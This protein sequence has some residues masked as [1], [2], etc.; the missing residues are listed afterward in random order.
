MEFR[1]SLA[2]ETSVSPFVDVS[3]SLLVKKITLK[4]CPGS[5]TSTPLSYDAQTT[6]TSTTI[7][8]TNYA[9]QTV[10]TMRPSLLLRRDDYRPSTDNPPLDSTWRV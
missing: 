2:E 1:P 8:T 6:T 7:A 9:D 3:A 5:K 10:T 4:W